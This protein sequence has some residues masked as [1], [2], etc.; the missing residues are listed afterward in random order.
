MG[1]APTLIERIQASQGDFCDIVARS[2]YVCLANLIAQKNIAP[3]RV[4]LAEAYEAFADE[5]RKK[6]LASH[7]KKVMDLKLTDGNESS[8]S[9]VDAKFLSEISGQ[10]LGD[11]SALAAGKIQQYF[12]AVASNS[13]TA[14]DV[15]QAAKAFTGQST[16][17]ITLFNEQILELIGMTCAPNQETLEVKP[18]QIAPDAF[19]VQDFVGRIL[20]I[21]LEKFVV[22]V[23]YDDKFDARKK[24]FPRCFCAPILHILR[25]LV[26]G[27]EKY[28][29]LND[30]L[31]TSIAKILGEDTPITT[32]HCEQF[33]HGEKIY[34]HIMSL[35]LNI[36]NVYRD[37]ELKEMFLEKVNDE[38]RK[39]YPDI[40][41]EFNTRFCTILFKCWARFTFDQTPDFTNMKKAE[42]ILRYHIPEMF[43]TEEEAWVR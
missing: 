9:E 42:N 16:V 8:C 15:D 33:L 28:L 6:H 27:R 12:S 32:K 31:K 4:P 3:Q 23:D 34:K 29:K 40:P 36:L 25:P 5:F 20:F 39:R 11:I 18:E 41:L 2:F 19:R 10:V 26:I 22:F 13:L 17:L 1:N 14:R 37:E 30:A 35:T 38:M 21:P 7:L 43:K 24:V